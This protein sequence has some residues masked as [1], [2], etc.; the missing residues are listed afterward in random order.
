ML[1][2]FAQ[3]V[4]ATFGALFTTGSVVLLDGAAN[5]D[6]WLT[7]V[8]AGAL[9]VVTAVAGNLKTKEEKARD[10]VV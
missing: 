8:V 9:A 2:R 6:T 4:V 10:S 7:T 1:S 3:K 5:A